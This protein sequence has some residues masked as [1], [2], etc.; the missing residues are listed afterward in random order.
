MSDKAIAELVPQSLRASRFAADVVPLR[1]DNRPPKSSQASGEDH[2]DIDVSEGSQDRSRPLSP[3]QSRQRQKRSGHASR[4]EG[5]NFDTLGNV[6]QILAS[7]LH[8]KQTDLQPSICQ[9]AGKAEHCPFRTSAAKIMQND[10]NIG[11]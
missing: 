2:H 3:Y 7:R 5:L 6:V 4:V 11:W 8:E 1:D 10:Q 9:S